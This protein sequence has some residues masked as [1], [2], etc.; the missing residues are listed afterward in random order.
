VKPTFF[1]PGLL[2]ICLAVGGCGG[3]PASP[4]SDGNRETNPQRLQIVCTT[5]MIEDL[6]RNLVGDK[7]DVHGIMRAGEDPHVY[8]V[9]PRDAEQIA[10]A[11]LILTNGFH[12]EATLEKV[13]D[14]NARGAVVP[15]A[16]KAVSKPLTGIDGAAPDPHCWMNVAY[17]RGYL[18]H[19]LEAVSSADPGNAL[20]YQK[21][22]AS[23]DAQLA[24]LNDWIKAEIASIPE[25]Q[26]VMVTSHDAFNYLADA[27]DIEVQAI[28]G[29]STA[30]APRP[31]E[32]ERIE[33]VIKDRNVRALFVETSVSSTLNMLVKKSAAATGVKI[34]GTLYSDSLDEPGKP[35]GSYLG[36]MNYNVS[37]IVDALQGS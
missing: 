12:L 37:T 7:A 35:A 34:G 10:D 17:F 3:P 4:A 30:Q 36:M 18:Q 14:N 33:A 32:I 21:N 16:E 2:L 1:L 31:Q 11:D 15:L 29:I 20:D 28:V 8:D 22:A 26:R 9:R 23:Y 27:Y 6:A 5:T 24:A 25:Q 19:A 13:I